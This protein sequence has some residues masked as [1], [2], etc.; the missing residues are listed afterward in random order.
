M[1][2]RMTHDAVIKWSQRHYATEFKRGERIVY[3]DG[4]PHTVVFTAH[5]TATSGISPNL[6]MN[7]RAHAE[8]ITKC[9]GMT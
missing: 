9:L 7:D 5:F 6:A 3:N 8:T 1:P 2:N 4:R